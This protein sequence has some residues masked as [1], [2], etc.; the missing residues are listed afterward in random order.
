MTEEDKDLLRDVC[1]FFAMQ[2]YLSNGDYHPSEI[3]RLSYEMADAMVQEREHTPLTAG[4]P[5]ITKRRRK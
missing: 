3:P 5:S 2:G 4:L 1:A